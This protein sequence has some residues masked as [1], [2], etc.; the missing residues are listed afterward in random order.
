MA[1]RTKKYVA[2]HKDLDHL[3]QIIEDEM[4]PDAQLDVTEYRQ[5]GLLGVGGKRMIEITATVKVSLGGV[6]R[7]TRQTIRLGDDWT[8]PV[9]A[10]EGARTSI[11]ADVPIGAP[12]QPRRESEPAALAS[13]AAAESVTRTEPVAQQVPTTELRPAAAE[14]RAAQAAS[15]AAGVTAAPT[16]DEETKSVSMGARMHTLK[17]AELSPTVSVK[18]KRTGPRTP[19]ARALAASASTSSAP[20]V[21]R[22]TIPPATPTPP[23]AEPPRATPPPV[24]SAVPGMPAEAVASMATASPSELAQDVKA[25]APAVQAA[26]IP[27]PPVEPKQSTYE[28][29]PDKY[30]APEPAAG[31]YEEFAEEV[32]PVPTAPASHLDLETMLEKMSEPA[33]DLVELQDSLDEIRQSLERMIPA[34]EPVASPAA[35]APAAVPEPATSQDSELAAIQREVYDQLVDWNVR[36]SD[37]L[38]L[39]EAALEHYRQSPEPTVRGLLTV[40]ASEMLR[41]LR[42]TPGIQL[43]PGEKRVVAVVGTTGT[44]KTSTV[45]K[46]AA[47][48]AFERGARVALISLD[49]YRIAAVEQLRTYAEIMGFP[50]SAAFSPDEYAEAIAAADVDLVLVDTAGRSPLNRKQLDDLR[51]TLALRPDEVH[52]TVPATSRADELRLTLAAFEDVGVDRVIVT[53]LD[54]TLSLGMLYNLSQLSDAPISYYSTGQAIPEDLHTAMP[55]FIRGWAETLELV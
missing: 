43:Y 49:T 15:E 14:L 6:G 28:P 10:E 32:Q 19:A 39:I 51:R 31:D 26:Q 34:T 27:A 25:V 21:A 55:G 12:I 54:E 16:A 40:V 48:F 24:E 35:P 18:T 22:A 9:P 53:K 3:L 42:S 11:R 46:L 37:A 5:G 8:K 47:H 4:G 50:L 23:P 38:A 20:P 36:S 30:S 1:T 41:P 52:L 44:G 29:I 7:A 45:A 17:A 13:A 33:T 2:E